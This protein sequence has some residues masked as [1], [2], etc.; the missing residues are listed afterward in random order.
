MQKVCGEKLLVRLRAL[1]REGF[2]AFS[3][4]EERFEIPFCPFCSVTETWLSSSLL[5]EEP[6]LPRFK[7]RVV[8]ITIYYHTRRILLLVWQLGCCQRGQISRLDR[9][10]I[11]K[12]PTT[13]PCIWTRLYDYNHNPESLTSSMLAFNLIFLGKRKKKLLL[14]N[15]LSVR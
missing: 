11:G 10:L 7:R 14:L 12:L 2:S 15:Y 4:R 8:T 9:A 1:V 13:F 5:Y 6:Q 3:P